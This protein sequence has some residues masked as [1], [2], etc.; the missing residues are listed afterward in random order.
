MNKTYRLAAIDWLRGFV[1]IIMTLDHVRDYVHSSAQDPMADPDVNGMLYFT[2]WISHLCAP[3]FVFLTGLSA[4]LMLQRKSRGEISQ[5]LFTRGLWLI[6]LEITVISLS[7]KFNFSNQPGVI[8]QVIWAIGVSMIALSA[9]VYLPR[10]WILGIGIVIVA[11]SNLLDGLLPPSTF[12][13][14]SP[15]WLAIHRQLIF[16]VGDISVVVAYPILSWVGIIACGYACAALYEQEPQQRSRRLAQWG[17]GLLA[18]FFVLRL[19]NVYGDPVSWQ[20]AE[21]AGK[22]VMR[23]FNVEKYPPSLLFTC[24]TLGIALLLLR[25]AEKYRFALY[26]A[27]VIFGRVPL[28]FYV[29]HL[30]LAHL[31]AVLFGMLQGFPAS[32][33]LTTVLAKP[34]GYGFN[35]LIVYLVWIAVVICL[36]P[37]CR[38]FS[39]LKAR[40]GFVVA[41]LFITIN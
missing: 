28:F 29:A 3:T 15:F 1:M 27:V 20:T 16:M 8:L 10:G 7:W 5:L 41:V 40:K 26:D 35:L 2:R 19:S 13:Q 34:A 12:A 37:A 14:P 24:V 30:Y 11:G 4:G 33:W 9:L 22:T 25:A 23:F 39:A 17:L 6:F 21:T 32:A 38:Y 36:Y 18:A 31:L